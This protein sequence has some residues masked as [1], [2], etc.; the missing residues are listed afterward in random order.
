MS[1]GYVGRKYQNCPE[2]IHDRGSITRNSIGQLCAHQLPKEDSIQSILFVSYAVATEIN[3][4]DA[5]MAL[6]QASPLCL[7]L[8]KTRAPSCL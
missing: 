4:M 7:V 5:G 8:H 6:L 1:L 3:S 2:I